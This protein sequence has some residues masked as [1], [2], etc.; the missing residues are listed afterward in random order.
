MPTPA[1]LASFNPMSRLI[2]T[3]CALRFTPIGY[4]CDG[5]DDDDDNG[6][7]AGDDGGQALCF[8]R[9]LRVSG[10]ILGLRRSLC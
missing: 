1:I 7:N 8:R 9:D 3:F 5:D 6:D 4:G 2:L 10:V